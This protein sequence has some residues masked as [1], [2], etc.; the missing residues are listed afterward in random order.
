M[1]T[2]KQG[3]FRFRTLNEAFGSYL[4]EVVRRREDITPCDEVT[5]AIDFYAGAQVVLEILGSY[6]EEDP[7]LYSKLT[8]ELRAYHA[9]MTAWTAKGKTRQ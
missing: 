6:V 7:Q 9:Q 1:Q 3:T 5:A 8:E 2:N 4:A